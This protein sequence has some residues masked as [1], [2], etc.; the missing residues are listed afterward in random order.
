MVTPYGG[1]VNFCCVF[2]A[3]K[4]GIGIDKKMPVCVYSIKLLVYRWGGDI[5]G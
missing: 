3:R 2:L 5:L 4:T 1:I